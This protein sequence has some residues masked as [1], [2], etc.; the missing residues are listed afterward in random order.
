M[1]NYCIANKDPFKSMIDTE[2]DLYQIM[3]NFVDSEDE[4]VNLCESRYIDMCDIEL[5]FRSNQNE[6]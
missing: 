3:S 6:Y 1:A 4:I 5:A 2:N